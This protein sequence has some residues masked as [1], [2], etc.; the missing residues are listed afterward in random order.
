MK[1]FFTKT[2]LLSLYVG[3]SFLYFSAANENKE[4]KKEVHELQKLK[5][6]GIKKG[7]IIS[8]ELDSLGNTRRNSSIIN[9]TEMEARIMAE[10]ARV[11]LLINIIKTNK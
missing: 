4:L 8:V 10:E 7:V 9:L 6:S 1:Q 11:E 2:F 3:I 5:Y